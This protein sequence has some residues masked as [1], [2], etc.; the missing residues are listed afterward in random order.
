MKNCIP[1]MLVLWATCSLAFADNTSLMSEPLMR[2]GLDRLRV[3][4][5]DAAKLQQARQLFIPHHLSSLQVKTIAMTFGDDGARLDFALAAYPRVVDPENFYEVYD[6][7][8]TFSKMMR[9]HDQI[10]MQPASGGMPPH[11]PPVRLVSQQDLDEILATIRN[12]S[13]DKDKL[14]LA[15]QIIGA[16]KAFLSR[17]I[18]EILRLFDFEDGRL[19]AAKFAYDYVVDPQNYFVVYDTFSFNNQKEQLAQYIEKKQR[20]PQTVTPEQPER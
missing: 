2:Q 4:Q 6:A 1:C 16:K 20:P 10:H 17:Q 13:F 19:D 3:E 18:K 7:F 15:R 11:V 14:R 9:L 5:G 12:A 8:H